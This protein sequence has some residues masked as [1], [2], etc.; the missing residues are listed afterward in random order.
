VNDGGLLFRQIKRASS[1]PAAWR[2]RTRPTAGAMAPMARSAR[3][4]RRARRCRRGWSRWG[5]PVGRD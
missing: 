4:T 5:R 3:A 2:P 1:T